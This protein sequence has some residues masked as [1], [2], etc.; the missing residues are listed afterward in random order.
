[1]EGEWTVEDEPDRQ[2][3]AGPADRAETPSAPDT[4]WEALGCAIT[5]R[6]GKVLENLDD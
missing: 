4:K 3:D 1:M 5:A 2:P 6:Y